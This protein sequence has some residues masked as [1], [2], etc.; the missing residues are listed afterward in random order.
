MR[1]AV[2]ILSSI[3]TLALGSGALRAEQVDLQLVLAADVSRSIDNDEFQLQREGIAAALQNPEV[4]RAIRS[5]PLGVV[6]VSFVE[7][8]GTGEQNVVVDW[9]LIRDEEGAGIVGEQVLKAPR[10]FIGRTSISEAIDFSARLFETSGMTSTRKVID[11]SGDGTNNS[12]RPIL[13]ARDEAVARGIVINGLAIINLN[14]NFGYLA[15]TQP[16]GGL[17][18]YYRDNVIGGPGSFVLQIEDFHSFAQAM[19]Q[20]LVQEISAAPGKPRSDLATRH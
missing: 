15:H 4:L 18:N 16:P 2:A 6:A 11:V 9:S 13:E 14:P 20:K 19:V 1:L 3:L 7:W 17:P 10:S 8:S 12:G 5:G